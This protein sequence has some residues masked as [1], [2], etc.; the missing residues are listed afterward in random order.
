MGADK[1]F[2]EIGGETFVRRTVNALKPNCSQVKI[3]LNQNQTHFIEKIPV[4][5]SY[6]F[7]IDENR[8]APGGMHTAFNDCATKFAVILAVDLPLVNAEAIAKLAQIAVSSNKY[9]AAVPRQTDERPQP[10]CAVYRA[11]F[12]LPTLEKLLDENESVSVNDFLDLI[13]P[14]YFAANFL[15]ENENLL[16]NVNQPNELQMIER[17]I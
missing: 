1:A 14:R 15:S 11:A 10:L 3:V 6:I 7:D 9:P 5:I 17:G 2:L 8:G 4:E 12:C 16:F 13:Y